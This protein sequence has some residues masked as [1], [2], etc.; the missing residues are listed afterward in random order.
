MSDRRQAVDPRII[1]ALDVA[2][3]FVARL[4]KTEG[5]PTAR[6]IAAMIGRPALGTHRQASRAAVIA[7]IAADWLA[8]RERLGGW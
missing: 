2:Q 7:A 4:P 8:M 5:R 3:E 6:Y 1:E